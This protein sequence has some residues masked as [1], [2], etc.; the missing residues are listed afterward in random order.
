MKRIKIGSLNR[1]SVI[2]DEFEYLKKYNWSLSPGGYAYTQNYKNKKFPNINKKTVFLHR[3]IFDQY[4]DNVLYVDHIN[5]NKLD[6]R[7]SNLRYASNQLNQYN[8]KK[9]DNNT[10]GYV[11]VT[12]CK[13]TSKWIAQITFNNKH[14]KIGRFINKK[15]AYKAYKS[16][17]EEIE[18]GIIL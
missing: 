9:P 16:K 3:I 13:T 1:F 4:K 7:M 15:D 6:N 10:S 12:Y 17:K 8:T 18:K 14:I 5:R 2:D 11:G